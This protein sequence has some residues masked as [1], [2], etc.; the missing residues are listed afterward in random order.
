MILLKLP[1]VD[2]DNKKLLFLIYCNL[3]TIENESFM[4]YLIDLGILDHLQYITKTVLNNEKDMCKVYITLSNITVNSLNNV[5]SIYEE[6][7]FHNTFELYERASTSELK[8]QILYFIASA[9]GVADLQI[10]TKLSK[11][12]LLELIITSVRF[13]SSENFSEIYMALECLYIVLMKG[14]NQSNGNR[15]DL[16]LNSFAEEFFNCKGLE[17]LEG[18]LFSKNEKIQL[19]SAKIFEE[20]FYTDPFELKEQIISKQ[21]L[22]EAEEAEKESENEESSDSEDAMQIVK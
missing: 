4:N 11:I 22:E 2:E 3:T 15:F 21:S 10:I 1:E 14:H 6:G 5:L 8:Y 7:I 12:R 9:C 13:A 18:H 16:S 19:I 17:F 20:F